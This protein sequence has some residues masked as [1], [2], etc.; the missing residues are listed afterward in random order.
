MIE[1]GLVDQLAGLGWKV[2]F[3]GHHQFENIKAEGDP[4][5]GMLKNPRLV[6]RVNESVAKAVGGHASKGHLPITLGGDHSLVCENLIMPCCG[7]LKA[8]I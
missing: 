2:N 5:I 8:F 4:P 3:D 1:A 6:S 7:K